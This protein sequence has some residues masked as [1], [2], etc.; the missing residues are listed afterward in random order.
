M[1]E[2]ETADTNKHDDTREAKRNTL[3]MEHKNVKIKE[4]RRLGN[5]S[6]TQVLSAECR[7][8][9]NEAAACVGFD[10]QFYRTESADM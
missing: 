8:N 6:L 4:R 7:K 9:S 1:G 10:F 5:V 3:D 2:V